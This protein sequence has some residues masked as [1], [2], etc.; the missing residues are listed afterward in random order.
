MEEIKLV[1][2]RKYEDK[3]KEYKLQ[4]IE[5]HE[6]EILEKARKYQEYKDELSRKNLII[7]LWHRI[8]QA[9][10]VKHPERNFIN[11]SWHTI[12]ETESDKWEI[13]YF[14]NHK[15]K[16]LNF[17][18]I[19]Y[20]KLV[21]EESRSKGILKIINKAV[22]IFDKL[23]LLISLIYVWLFPI[24]IIFEF[25]LELKCK[26][27]ISK[28]NL[29]LY[30]FGILLTVALCW[31]LCYLYNKRN[32][33][34]NEK[35]WKLVEGANWKEKLVASVL[36]FNISVRQNA[37]NILYFIILWYS[38]GLVFHA[39]VIKF[40][41]VEVIKKLPV[42]RFMWVINMYCGGRL[43]WIALR[44]FK[45]PFGFFACSIFIIPLFINTNLWVGI[46]LFVTLW[47]HLLT[48]KFWMLNFSREVPEYIMNPTD[49]SARIIEANLLK[50]KVSISIGVFLTYYLTV[51]VDILQ[52]YRNFL[53]YIGHL[54]N[55]ELNSTYYCN[56]SYF[57]DRMMV[58][59]VVIF[60]ILT[61]KDYYADNVK[62][63]A[64]DIID[65]SI[66]SVY[67]LI[68]RGVKEVEKPIFKE[69]VGLSIAYLDKIN[70]IQLL[71]NSEAL[72]KGIQ[73]FFEGTDAPHKR[74]V[75]V[76]MPD[77][78]VHSGIVEFEPEIKT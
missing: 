16:T 17:D 78:T 53:S 62:G 46:G 55:E 65:S 25:F 32:R 60:V 73:V 5:R 19:S 72:P 57:M 37:H 30:I 75:V 33:K 52:P 8:L 71:E 34:V 26:K 15:E 3:I 9:L 41:P 21:V 20:F 4:D 77:L 74:K 64:R 51:L 68:Y 43:V 61:I 76:I 48:N 12:Q 40:V 14:Y 69:K 27:S 10:R 42:E 1:K 11:S 2:S 13:A 45:S 56:L 39:E 31:G 29:G 44:L 54:S 28:V 36:S 58:F 63:A 49:N 22:G 6:Q 35:Q 7:R 47:T 24:L 59:V 38:V 18:D 23:L 50:I 66:A 70:P 67:D